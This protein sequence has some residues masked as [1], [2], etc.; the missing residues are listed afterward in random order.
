MNSS[1]IRK[2]SANTLVVSVLLLILSLFLI[3]K[4]V[5]SLNFIMV[6]LGCITVLDGIIHIVSYF[7]TSSELKMFSF[8]LVQGILGSILGFVFIFNPELIVSFLPFIIGAWI[9]VEGIIKFQFSFNIRGSELGNWFMPLCISIL[10]IIL[11]FIIVFNPFGTAIAITSL[12]GIFLLIS[13]ILNIVE[14]IYVIVKF[15]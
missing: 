12:A 6:L 14:S 8:E 13:E 15:K 5:T 2:Y 9:I 7:S 10:T 11:G 3:I 1:F 4:P